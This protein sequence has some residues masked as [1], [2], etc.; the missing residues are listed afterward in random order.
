M[1]GFPKKT[2]KK[3]PTYLNN[4][5][6]TIKNQEIDIIL[7]SKIHRPHSNFIGCSN[8]VLYRVG[9][10][11]RIR[12]CIYLSCLCSHLQFGTIY[13]SLLFQT[14]VFL[15]STGQLLYRIYFSWYIFHMIRFRLCIFSRP[16]A[17]VM[18]FSV[19]IKWHDALFILSLAM[20]T[21]ILG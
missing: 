9:I 19:H 3:T 18:L 17:A 6:T 11:H 7:P 14:M 21:L 13:L 15:R 2:N 4:Y 12:S 5:S 20:L 16:K 1:F 8:D 10:Q